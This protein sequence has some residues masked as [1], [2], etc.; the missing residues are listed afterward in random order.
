MNPSNFI[1]LALVCACFLS[2]ES[3]A[4]V[5][6]NRCRHIVSNE[7]REVCLLKL[8]AKLKTVTVSFDTQG[9]ESSNFHL[10]VDSLK[11]T[12]NDSEHFHW[13]LEKNLNGFLETKLVLESGH[14]DFK[15]TGRGIKDIVFEIHV[16]D[17]NDQYSVELEEAFLGSSR[18][19]NLELS[20][21]PTRVEARKL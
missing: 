2:F 13:I 10:Y 6:F 19:D 20:V 15:L 11:K 14:Y 4:S 3:R 17:S 16:S 8:P 7:K 12:R 9:I 18:L 1:A 21:N 5:D